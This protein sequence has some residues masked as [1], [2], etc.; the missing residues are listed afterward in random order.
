MLVFAVARPPLLSVFLYQACRRRRP[1][2]RLAVDA[3]SKT[4]QLASKVRTVRAL[5]LT[6]S[7][8]DKPRGDLAASSATGCAGVPRWAVPLYLAN[9]HSGS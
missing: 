4:Q 3:V 2:P 9:L 1:P 6:T 8:V 5:F 7:S